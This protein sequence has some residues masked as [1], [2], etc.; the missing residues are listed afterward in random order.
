MDPNENPFLF[1]QSDAEPFVRP[2]ATDLSPDPN[3]PAQ[4]SVHPIGQPDSGT[5]P[6]AEFAAASA[7]GAEIQPPEL[8]WQ[9]L[10]VP[11]NLSPE[12]LLGGL[13]HFQSKSDQYA[14]R[15]QQYDAMR[16]VMDSIIGDPQLGSMVMQYLD[17]KIKGQPI[18]NGV[19]PAY[20]QG[21]AQPG[22]PPPASS[23]APLGPAPADLFSEEGEQHLRRALER[24]QQQDAM[25]AQFQNQS[26]Q[27]Q[28]QQQLNARMESAVQ[29]TIYRYAHLGASRADAVE[30][31]RKL[32]SQGIG[33]FET[34]DQ[35][36]AYYFAQ[37]KPSPD[38]VR[39]QQAVAAAQ[40][41]TQQ[42]APAMAASVAGGGGVPS[43][44]GSGPFVADREG[45]D[46]FAPKRR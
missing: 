35:A 37:R 15:L 7:A 45:F 29:E 12:N 40:Q 17:A 26:Q 34:V 23:L 41:R 33:V 18:P 3:L 31:V 14:A 16:P 10:V 11:E 36:A 21:A 32:D 46:P 2:G 9:P 13:R 19:Q 42:R 28:Q 22:S 39:Q 38:Q 25:I 6:V 24:V 5:P 30:F 43:M 27:Q 20:G 1:G 44:N 8:P 4:E